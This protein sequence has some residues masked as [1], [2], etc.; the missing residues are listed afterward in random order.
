MT[1]PTR[2]PRTIPT[3]APVDMLRDSDDDALAATADGTVW[4]VE[5]GV[6][7]VDDEAGRDV[8][9][10]TGVEEEELEERT[11]ALDEE[12]IVVLADEAELETADDRV[13]AVGSTTVWVYV[14][15]TV[16]RSVARVVPFVAG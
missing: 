4:T 3:I 14:L 15:A 6:K 7:D 16:D 10:S 13:A 5:L 9:V 2:P 8:M 11:I 12:A 1:T